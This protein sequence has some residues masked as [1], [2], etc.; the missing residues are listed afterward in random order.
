MCP[1][2][3]PPHSADCTARIIAP[4]GRACQTASP[5]TSPRH[6]SAEYAQRARSR[7]AAGQCGSGKGHVVVARIRVVDG[8]GGGRAGPGGRHFGGQTQVTQDPP[9]HRG[10]SMSAISARRVPQRGHARTSNP[11][12][13]S[14]NC[15]QEPVR[16]PPDGPAIGGRFDRGGTPECRPHSLG[17]G[18]CEP[19]APR[20][21]RAVR[22]RA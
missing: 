10:S 19:R 16:A 15:A 1:P 17:I 13:R 18:P 9:D 5:G 20:R 14:I 6:T 3:S 21:P 22:S 7:R 8:S 2:P 12:L 4:A 11:K